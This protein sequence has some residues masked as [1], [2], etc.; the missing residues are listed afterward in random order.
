MFVCVCVFLL[1]FRSSLSLSVNDL[2]QKALKDERA[3]AYGEF[4]NDL[5]KCMIAEFPEK[6]HSEI[7]K[8]DRQTSR[9]HFHLGLDQL[10]CDGLCGLLP[11]VV[12]HHP[13]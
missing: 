3:L 10:L 4:I 9:S 2:F 12:G 8:R 11:S 13:R 5:S 7:E 6:V 1:I